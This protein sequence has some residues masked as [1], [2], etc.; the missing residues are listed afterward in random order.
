MRSYLI[1][2]MRGEVGIIV[3]VLETRQTDVAVMEQHEVWHGTGDQHVRTNVK[4]TPVQQ[5]W[6]GDVSEI[7]KK[8][9]EIIL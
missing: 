2:K 3:L 9:G 7:I 6:V 5:Q 8:K 4:L 1:G